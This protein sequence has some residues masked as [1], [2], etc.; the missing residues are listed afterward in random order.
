MMKGPFFA[1]DGRIH[2][3]EKRLKLIYGILKLASLS[4]KTDN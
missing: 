4:Q 1:L 3:C 2:I